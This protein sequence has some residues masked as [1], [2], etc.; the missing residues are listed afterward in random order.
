MSTNKVQIFTS[1]GQ[2]ILRHGDLLFYWNSGVPTPQSLQ[3][4]LTENCTLSCKFCSVANRSKKYVIDY[5]S[6]IEATKAFDELGIKTVEISGGGDPLLY[7]RLNDYICFLL[8]LKLEVGLITNGI[9]INKLLNKDLLKDMSWIRISANVLDYR[10][11]IEIPEGFTG[12]LG[13]SYCWTEGLSTKEQLLRIKDIAL[14][15][16]VKYIR[17]VPNCL[18]TKEELQ[19]QHDF[20]EPLAQE[21]G[22]PIFYQKKMFDTFENC[23]WGYIKP[24]LYPD[25]YVYPCSSTVL[26]P[27]ADKQF[28]VNYRWCHWTE[29][30]KVWEE[31]P[32]KSIIDTSKCNHCVF[33]KQNMLLDYAL[34][35]QE[36]ENFV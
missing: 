7:P 29:I 19:K 21:I 10:D 3:V 30:K 18:S 8:I 32:I 33:T 4:G 24:F 28:N 22:E 12:T 6:L 26:N 23:Y 14:K 13:F 27:D 17:L 31:I 1:T 34:K 5:D 11:A 9:G 36:H 16:N 35:K 15:N 2:K 20:L 25:G